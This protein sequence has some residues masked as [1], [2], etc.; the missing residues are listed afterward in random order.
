METLLINSD[1]GISDQQ[2]KLQ[3]VGSNPQKKTRC[4]VAIGGGA[5]TGRNPSA[6]PVADA[7]ARARCPRLLSRR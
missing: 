1:R 5:A 7:S 6:A 4:A 2:E 3:E